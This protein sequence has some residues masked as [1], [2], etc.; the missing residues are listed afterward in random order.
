M[1]KDISVLM[2]IYEKD[3]PIFFEKALNSIFY[4]TL[5][6]KEIVLV[7]DGPITKEAEEIIEKKK[8]EM[9]LV[10]VPLPKQ[11]SL[12]AALQKGLEKCQYSLVAR[13]DSDDIA[14]ENRL[15]KEADFL[16]NH[17]EICAVGSNIAEFE[18]EGVILR[19]KKMPETKAEVYRYGKYRNPLNHM[20]VLFRKSDIEEVGGYQDVAGLEDYDLWIRLLAEDKG[21]ANIGEVLVEARLGD[22]FS[23]RRGG[24]EY[25]EIYKALR[26]RQHK[27]GYTNAVEYRLALAFT[28]GMTRSS[29]TTRDKFYEKLRK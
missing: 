26:A 21:I 18:E 2:S 4:Q 28:Y 23:E 10:L 11:N 29:N 13:M 19:E 25:Y 6:P 17:P 27:L 12:G 8:N 9:N 24:K 7:L 15:E 16:E 22:N 3:N 5:P 20:T 1:S 14:K